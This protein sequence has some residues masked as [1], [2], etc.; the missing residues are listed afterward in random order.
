MADMVAVVVIISDV[1]AELEVTTG[2]VIETA[3]AVFLSVADVTGWSP[4]PEVA[5]ILVIGLDVT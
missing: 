3:I 5:I 1:S 2:S 4:E